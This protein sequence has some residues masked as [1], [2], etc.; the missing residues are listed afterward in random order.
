MHIGFAAGLSLHTI[1]GAGEAVSVQL[2]F[3]HLTLELEP[4]KADSKKGK[5]GA[6]SGGDRTSRRPLCELQPM[7]MPVLTAS[8]LDGRDF[9]QKLGPSIMDLNTHSTGAGEVGGSSGERNSCRTAWLL[10]PPI[11]E[12]SVQIRLLLLLQPPNLTQ[13]LCSPV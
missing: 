5:M 13:S 1:V 2:L 8:D 7:R 9:L 4:A 11:K 3:A 10:L 12:V 6:N